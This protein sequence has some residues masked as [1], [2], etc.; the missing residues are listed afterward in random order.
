MINTSVVHGSLN[1]HFTICVKPCNCT[2]F[3][4]IHQIFYTYDYHTYNY[5]S[6]HLGPTTLI[7]TTP[8]P[9]NSCFIT[10]CF[11]DILESFQYIILK[12]FKNHLLI[13]LC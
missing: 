13:L 8:N 6:C 4:F 3:T 9:L 11:Q 10:I 1:S 12:D 5:I 2:S 7:G